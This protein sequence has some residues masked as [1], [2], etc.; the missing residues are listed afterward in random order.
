MQEVG[1][2]VVLAV[3]QEKRNKGTEVLQMAN[4]SIKK[5]RAI[6]VLVREENL[7]PVVTE[8]QNVIVVKE[9]DK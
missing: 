4:R 1:T 2:V 5:F 3:E 7:A 9:V 8:L 6:H